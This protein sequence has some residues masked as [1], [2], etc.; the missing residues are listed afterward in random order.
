MRRSL[1]FGTVLTCA[2]IVSACG[3]PGRPGDAVQAG[4]SNGAPTT[5]APPSVVSPTLLDA[6]RYPT[7]PL[8]PLGVSNDVIVGTTADAQHLADFVVGPWQIDANLTVPYL[9]AYYVVTAPSALEQLGPQSVAA[10]AG[11]HGLVNGFA[12][13]RQKAGAVAGQSGG[14]AVINAVL[15]FPDPGAA[16]V[17]VTD[18]AAAAAA[19]PI[20]GVTPTGLPIPGHPGTVASTYPFTPQG[21]TEPRAT[22]R[23]FT[24]HG[25]YVFMQFVQSVDGLD[26]ATGLVVKAIDAQ[27]PLIDQFTPST[28]LAAVPLDPSGLLARTL[29]AAGVPSA[30]KNAVYGVRGAQ[31]FQTNPIG[32]QTLFKDT[33]ITEVAMGDTNVYRTRNPGAAVMVTNS[34][35]QEVSKDDAKPADTVT[36]L[37]DSHCWA[38]PKGFYCVA[39]AGQFAIEARSEQLADVHQQLAAQ[40]VML[41]AT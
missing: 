31:H 9:Q 1:Q 32:S 30:A 19:Q 11:R 6:G 16:A 7:K 4:T 27:G 12:S 21:S 5:V 18:M 33:G 26:A 17:A 25:A 39:P 40:Y 38:L 20:K 37:P 34:F 8:P 15:R 35:S 41:T 23:A 14:S 13:A 29:P 10:A 36:A 24:P 3:G 22:I 2:L 28:D